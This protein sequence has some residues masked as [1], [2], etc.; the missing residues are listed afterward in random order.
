VSEARQAEDA[1]AQT[2]GDTLVRTARA[3]DRIRSLRGRDFFARISMLGGELDFEGAAR[4]GQGFDRVERTLAALDPADALRSARRVIEPLFRARA[5]AAAAATLWR[6]DRLDDARAATGEALTAARE[7]TDADTH[8]AFAAVIEAALST[9]DEATA[10]VA[11]VEGAHRAHTVREPA[12]RAAALMRLTST[13]LEAGALPASTRN[14]LSR[15]ALGPDIHFWGRREVEAP[16]VEGLVSLL[17]PENADTHLFLQKVVAHPSATVRAG[18]VRTMPLSEIPALRNMLLA[19]LRDRD[20][21]V[22]I[23]VIERLGASGDRGLVL[24]LVNACR[25]V[26]GDGPQSPPTPATREEKRALLLNLARL[27]GERQLPLINAFLGGLHTEGPGLSDRQRPLKDDV[28]LQLAALEVLIH[29]RSRGA[30]RLVFNAAERSRRAGSPVTDTFSAVWAVLKSAPYGDAQLPRSPHDPAW[31]EADRFDLDAW[32]EAQRKAAAPE[33]SRPAETSAEGVEETT[34]Q[35]T[36]PPRQP[37]PRPAPE[38]PPRP[39]L[40]E[41]LKRK[42]LGDSMAAEASIQRAAVEPRSA[43]EPPTQAESEPVL[44]ATSAPSPVVYPATL[45]IE[46]YIEDDTSSIA[47]SLTLEC[48]LYATSTDTVPLWRESV[49]G[50]CVGRR[51]TLELGR[52]SPLPAPIPAGAWLDLGLP[53]ASVPTAR[54]QLSRARTVVH[55]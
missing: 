54:I 39:G 18:V 11:V 26:Q 7:C 37:S 44:H 43:P 19:H 53:E 24:Y 50:R 52:S 21:D 45:I 10:E 38:P 40:F 14:A 20:P 8:G 34:G 23:E 1:G 31:T 12:E 6:L 48:T 16:L 5:L 25:H 2:E 36:Q 30:R 33:P 15:S 9:Q 27:D 22:R 28:D 35:P 47:S 17:P 41:R 32:L 42:F 49:V 13:L 29:L 4:S 3:L 46:T 51:L 55:G